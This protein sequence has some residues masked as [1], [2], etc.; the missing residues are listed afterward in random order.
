MKHDQLIIRFIHAEQQLRY[1]KKER[2]SLG[3][4]LAPRTD[5]MVLK[6]TYWRRIYLDEVISQIDLIVPTDQLYA[7]I[8]E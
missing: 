2:K 4:L 3:T 1:W 5:W 7:A 8:H 6:W